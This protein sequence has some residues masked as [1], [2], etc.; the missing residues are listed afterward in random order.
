MIRYEKEKIGQIHVELTNK[1]NAACPTCPRNH[2]GKFNPGAAGKLREYSFDD[3]RAIFENSDI[4]YHTD[5]VMYCGNYG[6]PGMCTDLPKI[7]QWVFEQPQVPT[8]DYRSQ[9]LNTNG[10]MRGTKFWSEIGELMNGFNKETS[11]NRW[12]EV[13]WSIDGLEDTNHLFRR[14]VIWDKVWANLNAFL[15]A[16]GRGTWEFIEWGHN[17]HQV[18]EAK[19]IAEDL[20]MNFF[21]KR[22][23]G[24]DGSGGL[25]DTR[26]GV[27]TWDKN[28]IYTG[29]IVS[30][31]YTAATG[32]PGPIMDPEYTEN[33][34]YSP[35]DYS[36]DF[37]KGPIVQEYEL[38]EH[39]EKNTNESCIRCRSFGVEDWYGD[40]YP[41]YHSVYLGSDGIVYPCCYVHGQ[42]VE[43]QYNYATQQMKKAWAPVLE[44]FKVLQGKSIDDIVFG[45][46]M[47]EMW[48]KKSQDGS[49]TRSGKLAYCADTC[50][51]KD[52]AINKLYL[53]HKEKSVVQNAGTPAALIPL[54]HV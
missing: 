47:F 42:I 29:S 46:D 26:H 3:F 15:K 19:K 51:S 32:D 21:V 33:P 40:S 1:C 24:F 28:S 45:E 37:A 14:N 8:R 20:G 43:V 12:G 23:L 39:I 25:I 9:R 30:S 50:G 48:H 4:L 27:P 36:G 10:G 31:E 52:T 38:E 13:V 34:M 35:G 5:M 22:A 6:D 16:G 49:D 41:D 18:E 53:T 2:Y 54:K 7:L 44:K 11:P 17:R